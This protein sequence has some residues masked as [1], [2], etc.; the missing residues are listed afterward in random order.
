MIYWYTKMIL[1][2]K[3]KYLISPFIDRSNLYS[4]S[5]SLRTEFPY[6][7]KDDSS[8]ILQPLFSKIVKSARQAGKNGWMTTPISAGKSG[9][10]SQPPKEINLLHIIK[11]VELNRSYFGLGRWI[12]LRN[13]QKWIL[14]WKIYRWYEKRIRI[15]W[16]CKAI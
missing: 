8:D 13:F 10:R 11:K 7:P 15:C 3:R 9:H 4:S 16:P 1:F 2:D 14:W 6:T 5:D 12:N